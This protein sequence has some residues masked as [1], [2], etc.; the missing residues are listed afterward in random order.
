[1]T[2][3]SL[4]HRFAFIYLSSKGVRPSADEL[5]TWRQW[6]YT[7]FGRIR[8]LVDFTEAEISP[9]EFLSYWT[10]NSRLL[11]STAHNRHPFLLPI[12]N[13]WFRAVHDW[14]HLQTGAGFDLAGERQTFYH[15]TTTAPESIW[16]ILRSEIVLQASVAIATGTFPRQKL[17]R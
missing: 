6:I 4:A 1:M 12:E 7:S 13:A 9:E 2:R 5:Q 11:I 3:P 14:H 15:A 16:W 8:H 17:V 10:K